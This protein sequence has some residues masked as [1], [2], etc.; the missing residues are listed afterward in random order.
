MRRAT[1]SKG[2]VALRSRAT[3]AWHYPRRVPPVSDTL[4]RARAGAVHLFTASGAAF[5]LLAVRELWAPEPDPRR[6][7][8]WLLVAVLI[9]AVDGPLARRWNVK[10]WAGAVDGRTIDDIVDYL[11]FTFVPLLLVWRM[12]WLPAPAAAYVAVA[13]VASLLGFAHREAKQEASGFF[14]GFPS[15]WNV[16]AFYAGLW[17][18][19]YGPFLPAVVLVLLSALTVMP[20]RFL[21]P[22]LAPAPWRVPLIVG[23]VAW[24]GLLM[25]ML[26]AYPRPPAWLTG[27]SLVYPTF[28]VVLSLALDARSRGPGWRPPG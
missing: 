26:P 10:T 28:Y 24:A 12:G 4:L 13:L 14:R 3:P 23:A 15:Y 25:A 1:T 22:N 2:F 8:A 17:A 6:V 9:D 20:V 27:A 7:F 21:Y 19:R 18:V 5:D 16:Y 11:T